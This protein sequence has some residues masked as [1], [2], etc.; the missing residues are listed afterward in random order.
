MFII[1]LIIIVSII[2]HAS[3][4]HSTVQKQIVYFESRMFLMA[5]KCSQ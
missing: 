1:S 2:I 4:K 5:Y 3:Y